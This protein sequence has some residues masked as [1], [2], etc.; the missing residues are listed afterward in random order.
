M[1]LT[2]RRS[3]TY[4]TSRINDMIE[5]QIIISFS[6]EIGGRLKTFWVYISRQLNLN[7]S[8]NCTV[9]GKHI[10]VLQKRKSIVA[11]RGEPSRY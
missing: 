4:A 3:S 6:D 11:V 1:A 10:S 8:M 5:E 7:K 9:F 2:A